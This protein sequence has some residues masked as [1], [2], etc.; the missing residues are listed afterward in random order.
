MEKFFLCVT[1][2][3]PLN[4]AALAFVSSWIV[5]VRVRGFQTDHQNGPTQAHISGSAHTNASTTNKLQHQNTNETNYTTSINYKTNSKDKYKTNYKTTQPWLEF[6]LLIFSSF[7]Q[8]FFKKLVLISLKP[9]RNI[10]S[11]L[12]KIKSNHSLHIIHLR[13]F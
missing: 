9:F 10:L 6:V 7:L 11:N 2:A 5:L 13:F 1:H 12:R 4:P 3:H 8:N